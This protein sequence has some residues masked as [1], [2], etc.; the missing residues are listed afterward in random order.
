MGVAIQ[1][2]GNVAMGRWGD[3]AMGRCGDSSRYR[4]ADVLNVSLLDLK[5]LKATTG[6]LRKRKEENVVTILVSRQ[7]GGVL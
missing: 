7:A 6:G 1:Q 5:T 3:G 2:C 4:A